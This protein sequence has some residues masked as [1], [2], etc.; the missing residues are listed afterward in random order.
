[1]AVS[2][3]QMIVIVWVDLLLVSEAIY[4]SNHLCG[5]VLPSLL[6]AF[7]GEKAGTTESIMQS[8]L[9]KQRFAKAS[10]KKE[11][12][13]ALRKTFVNDG[14]GGWGQNDQNYT[15]IFYNVAYLI[16]VSTC[17]YHA[18]FLISP[19]TLLFAQKWTPTIR[20]ISGF[21]RS[22]SIGSLVWKLPTSVDDLQLSK[23]R[24]DTFDVTQL[25]GS[26][27]TDRP[28]FTFLI[29]V[30]CPAECFPKPV[31]NNGN[32]QIAVK[33]DNIRIL[34]IYTHTHFS[35]WNFIKFQYDWYIGMT[36]Q[37]DLPVAT[38][39]SSFESWSA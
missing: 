22:C 30:V 4:K 23:G 33:N 24:F 31:T 28:P 7:C 15:L 35:G 20:S 5:Q 26:N 11:G 21:L 19:V 38:S 37:K 10:C 39:N 36:H 29:Y 6:S 3:F 13:K 12:H 27:V 25:D 9:P 1:M 18:Q 32:R 17:F 2:T 14:T 34:Y 16:Y 8:L